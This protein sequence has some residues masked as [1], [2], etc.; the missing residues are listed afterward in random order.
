MLGKQKTGTTTHTNTHRVR[1][2]E[3]KKIES[4]IVKKRKTNMNLIQ[5][6]YRE[7]NLHILNI[8]SVNNF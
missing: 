4:Y 3:T 5:N 1:E 2:T 8:N 7:F 6:E